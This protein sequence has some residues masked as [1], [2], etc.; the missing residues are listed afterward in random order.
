[1]FKRIL[2]QISLVFVIA[3][4]TLVGANLVYDNSAGGSPRPADR[5]KIKLTG[6]NTVLFDATID[7][8]SID[9]SLAALT[10]KRLTLPLSQTVYI[11][12]ASGG[13]NYA[14]SL[15]FIEAVKY[16]PNL[17][18]ICKYCGSAAGM[19]FATAKHGQEDSIQ[20][21]ALPLD[22]PSTEQ[23]AFLKMFEAL[24]E[25]GEQGIEK[26]SWNIHPWKLGNN[27][28]YILVGPYSR[29]VEP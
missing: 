14:A 1:M 5:E 15:K 17:K 8:S 16:F 25:I 9:T 18:M 7:D 11:L 19:I 6:H 13:G 28:P 10:G 2:L 22:G 3:L 20:W 27:R 26:R 12:I 29:G 21:R 24:Q 4:A 23:R